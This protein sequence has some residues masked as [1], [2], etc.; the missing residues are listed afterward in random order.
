MQKK[1]SA[2]NGLSELEERIIVWVRVMK[3]ASPNFPITKDALAR[4]FGR[5]R[6]EI[7]EALYHLDEDLGLVHPVFRHPEDL[8]LTE[9]GE[10]LADQF[11]VKAESPDDGRT[12][13]E[14]EG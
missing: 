8:T 12:Q 11:R 9:G 2:P 3:D 10:K 5:H 14:T 13:R 1:R 7:E 6:E 4:K